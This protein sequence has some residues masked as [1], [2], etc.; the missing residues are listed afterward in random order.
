MSLIIHIISIRTY[1]SRGGGVDGETHVSVTARLAMGAALTATAAR[2]VAAA[3]N[4]IL[5]DLVFF[6]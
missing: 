4:F 5:I 1:I 6:V 3:A 2:T